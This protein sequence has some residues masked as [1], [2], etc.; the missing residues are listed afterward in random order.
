MIGFLWFV[1]FK[2][3]FL[4]VLVFNGIRMLVFFLNLMDIVVIGLFIL[5]ILLI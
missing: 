1:F 2:Y 3:I 4:S 5:S